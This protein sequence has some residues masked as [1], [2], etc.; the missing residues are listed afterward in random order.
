MDRDVE[1]RFELIAVRKKTGMQKKKINRR[2]RHRTVITYYPI[3]SFTKGR[4]F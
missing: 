2:C 4:T 3:N 1:L